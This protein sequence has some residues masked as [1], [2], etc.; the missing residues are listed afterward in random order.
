MYLIDTNVLSELMR[1]MA[2]MGV[3]AWF[4]E[5]NSASIFL[6]TITLAEIESGLAQ[7][8]HGARQDDLIRR[9][10]ATVSLFEPNIISFD[11][12]A[13]TSFGIIFARCRAKGRPISMGDGLIAAVAK[14]NN[15]CVVTRDVSGFS[16][17]EVDVINPWPAITEF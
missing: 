7:M 11:R 10:Q 17:A 12:R 6:S 4:D 15:L 3:V 14:A 16:A 1:P 13:A 5:Q 8:P 2:N 9:Y